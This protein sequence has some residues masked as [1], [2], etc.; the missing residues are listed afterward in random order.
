M[1]LHLYGHQ[2]SRGVMLLCSSPAQEFLGCILFVGGLLTCIMVI[3]KVFAH[4][5]PRPPPIVKSHFWVKH[6]CLAE[7]EME[8]LCQYW[9]VVQLKVSGPL[10]DWVGSSVLEFFSFVCLVEQ[11]PNR[12]GHIYD[13]VHIIQ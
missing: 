7:T 8:M 12:T 13:L 11:W 5:T 10:P 1:L 6:T 3:S 9:L 2:G 4:I